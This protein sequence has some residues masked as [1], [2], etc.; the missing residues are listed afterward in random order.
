MADAR[1]GRKRARPGGHQLRPEVLAHHLRERI[2]AGAARAIAERGYRQTTVADIVRAAAIARARF[3]EN[4]SSKQDCFLALYDG[5][6][7][8]SI[9]VV[10]EACEAERGDFPQRVRAGVEALIAQLESDPLL[11]RACIVEGPAAGPAIDER[12]EHLIGA[13]AARLRTGREEA[14]VIE[15]ADT[16][17]ETVVGGLYWLLYYALLEGGPESLEPLV[18][19]LI[20]FSLIPLIGAEAA[21][22]AIP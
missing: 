4:F 20:E 11:A 10:S 7:E 18:P 1:A 12:F 9:G 5:A 3:Y 17:E 2:L 22:T 14:G 6:V 19:Q 21:R 13:F 16:V 15:L 8:A